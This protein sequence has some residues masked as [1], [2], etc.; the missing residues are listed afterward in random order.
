KFVGVGES[1]VADR[2]EPTL[3]EI[4]GL[5]IGYCAKTAEVDLRCIG[6]RE[7]L[8]IAEQ[9]VCAA[10]PEELLGA[11]NETLE[12]MVVTL[13]NDRH[14]WISVAESC[15]GGMIAHRI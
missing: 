7:K 15:T 14:E 6:P 2:L 10:F 11:G 12:R 13:L 5:E 8:E 3:L 9:Q 4:G 1:E